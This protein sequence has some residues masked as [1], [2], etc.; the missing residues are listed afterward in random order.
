M[1]G[2]ERPRLGRNVEY[3]R[4][5]PVVE[6]RSLNGLGSEERKKAGVLG[7]H[8]EDQSRIRPRDWLGGRKCN[9]DPDKGKWSTRRGSK[10]VLEQS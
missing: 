4:S 3:L 5:D 9:H 10:N 8:N 2:A 1:A 7:D 6:G